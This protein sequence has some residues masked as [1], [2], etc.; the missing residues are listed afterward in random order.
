MKLFTSAEPAA[1]QS[2][3]PAVSSEGESAQ[4]TYFGRASINSDENALIV[5]GGTYDLILLCDVREHFGL[6]KVKQILPS[7]LQSLGVQ[8]EPRALPVGDFLWIIRWR[9]PQGELHEAVLDYLVERKRADDLAHSITDGRFRE[10]KYRMKRTQISNRFF[11]IEECPSMRNQR[12]PFETLLQATSNCQVIDGFRVM[13]TRSPEDTVDWLASLTDRLRSRST[14][15]IRISSALFS[16]LPI[17]IDFLDVHV[18]LS[19]TG[20]CRSCAVRARPWLDFVQLA[21]KSPPPTV[22]DMFAKQL[23]Q[24]HGFSGPKVISLLQV[25]PTPHHLFQAYEAR[26]TVHEK[27]NMLTSLKLPGT[28]R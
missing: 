1:H 26:T 9:G 20:S 4:S 3:L 25:Y 28:N 18:S 7:V 8:C 11:L 27:E 13:W 5:P 21:Q 6:N 22:R 19:D 2:T 23:M 24:I 17:A 10:Q 15:R 12:I 16:F 14:V